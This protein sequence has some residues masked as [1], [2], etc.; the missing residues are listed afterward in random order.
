MKHWPI[1]L[2]LTLWY[3]GSLAC[4]LLLF[5][6]VIDTLMY[7]RMLSRTDAELTEEIAELALEVRLATSKQELPQALALRFG[8]HPTFQFAVHD[9]GGRPIFV[10]PGL[11]NV[12]PTQRMEFTAGTPIHRSERIDGL[13]PVRVA[14][15]RVSRA[16][17]MVTIQ[18]IISLDRSLAEVT[19]LRRLL[20]AA[21]LFEPLVALLGGYL[22]AGRM[23]RP[24]EKMLSSA[25]QIKA[26]NLDER[27]PVANSHDEIGRLGLTLNRM[28]DRVQQ[29]V[30]EQMQF[31]ADAAHE[32][33]TP[34]AVIRSTVELTLQR[35]RETAFYV[36]CLQTVVEETERLTRLSNQL[37]LL[38]RERADASN[39][40][41]VAFDLHQLLKEVSDDVEPLCEVHELQLW[42]NLDEPLPVQGDRERL[43]RVILNL[44]SNAVQ[45]TPAGGT[46][47]IGGKAAGDRVEVTVSDTG[48]GISPEHLPH[49]F[50]RFYRVEG[51]RNRD[52]GGSGLGLAICQAI[53]ENHGGTIT[54]A[55]NAPQGTTV[56]VSL[57]RVIPQ[58][59]ILDLEAR[60]PRV[61]S[62]FV[63]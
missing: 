31:T 4:L 26:T 40:G 59:I 5:G 29:S 61:R 33:R 63:P 15:Q 43:R 50:R 20:L 10:S 13:G 46:V 8:G 36:E 48:T 16:D 14:S 44:M 1:R 51:S 3:A 37:L 22:L 24:L 17:G 7:R 21:G 58:E 42:L 35:H 28:L 12:L 32:L 53:V 6:F 23:L 57:P 60:P 2:R 39:T 9:Q 56:R 30:D 19:D 55:A 62:M 34:L 18:V 52:S 54:I 38:A 11:Q 25:D 45:Y 49:L 27:I 47:K 41:F